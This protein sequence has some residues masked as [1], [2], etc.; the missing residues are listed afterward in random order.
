MVEYTKE[1]DAI[2]HKWVGIIERHPEVYSGISN[3]LAVI[4][5]A[6]LPRLAEKFDFVERYL[7]PVEDK[8]LPNINIGKEGLLISEIA[9]NIADVYSK[10]EI[11]FYKQELREIVEI[12]KIKHDEDDKS[13]MGF[14]IIKPKRFITLSEKHFVPTIE[15]YKKGIG[16]VDV[17]KSL[18]NDKSNIILASPQFQEAM[19]II[20]RIFSVPMPMMYDG[21]LSF[22]KLGYDERFYSWLNPNAPKINMKNMNVEE[23]KLIMEK[24]FGEFCF[25]DKQDYTNAVAGLITPF[26]R[27]LYTDFSARTPMFFYV[28]NRERAGKDYLA[29]I[30]G[31]A[32]EGQALDEPPISDGEQSSNKNDELRKK[33][34]SSLLQGRRRLHFAN[35]KG[36]LNNSVLEAALTS[37]SI[38]DR[39]L[40]KNE[41]VSVENELDFSASG[42]VGITFTPDLSNRCIFVKLFL[43]IENA[44]DREFSNPNL[45]GWVMNNR[46]AILSAI[47]C[48]I[49]DWVKRGS[50]P[51]SKRFASFPEWASICGGIMEN[52]GLGSPCVPNNEALTIGGDTESI[53]MKQLFE[54]AYENKPETP[55]T[56]SELIGIIRDEDSLL[57]YMDWT[58][59]PDQAKFGKKLIK[60]YGRVFSDIRLKVVNP[61]E[62]RTA[63]HKLLFTKVKREQYKVG[64]VGN[65]CNVS[66][67]TPQKDMKSLL[68]SARGYQHYQVN[69]NPSQIEQKDGNVFSETI[70]EGDKD[71]K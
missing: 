5:K 3:D 46:S 1:Q 41:V 9:S 65:V 66:T 4:P 13:F 64:N 30:T 63:R 7:N 37:K 69:E 50:K 27:G 14:S 45:H 29:S 25:E 44:N 39:M 53:E 17:S 38:S 20:K 15:V 62:K 42:N 55:I 23:A 67:T 11:L 34:L 49:E 6:L 56:K 71:G 8:T 54:L 61:D 52:A 40:G 24:L 33:L 70:K 19:P 22:P 31:L 43:D 51:G 10:K 59:R 32:L 47:F 35:N 18:S 21:E 36:R 28:A 48:L 58:A 60:F 68:D 2:Y 16:M 26:L 57:P 12:S